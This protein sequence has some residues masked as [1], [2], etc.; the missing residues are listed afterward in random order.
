LT[1]EI[2]NW[3]DCYHFE[4]IARDKLSQIRG[5]DKL[6][7]D[8]LESDITPRRRLT[9]IFNFIGEISKVLFGTLDSITIMTKL[10]DQRTGRISQV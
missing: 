7:K 3:T 8:L 5:S 10:D 9:G 2:R 6:L 4:A 1:T